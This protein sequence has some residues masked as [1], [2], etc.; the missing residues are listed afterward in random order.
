MQHVQPGAQLEH[1]ASQ[2]M[3]QPVQMSQTRLEPQLLRRYDAPLD[4]REAGG[5]MVLSI[6]GQR[7]VSCSCWWDPALGKESGD[8]SVLV[9]VYT[10]TNGYYW[11]HGLHYLKTDPNDSDDAATQQCKQIIQFLRQHHALHLHIEVNGLGQFL[12]SLLAQIFAVEKYPARIIPVT[13]RQNKTQRILQTLDPVLAARALSVHDTI[14]D[15]GLIQEM[16]EFN[17]ARNTNR[18]DALDAL[19]GALSAQPVRLPRLLTSHISS[20]LPVWRPQAKI[21]TATSSDFSF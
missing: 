2:M 19:C 1:F 13:A 12:P 6:A 3:L 4:L 7:M 11:L 16:Q 10:D 15:S 5:E 18:D 14:W 20:D 21:F 17:P 8:R 9:C